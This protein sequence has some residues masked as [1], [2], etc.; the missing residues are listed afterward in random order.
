MKRI[1]IVTDNTCDLPAELLAKHEIAVVPLDVRLGDS[2]AAEMRGI[3]AEQ[4][5]Q[6]ARRSEALA[7]TSAP[8]PGAF[9][10][11]FAAAAD[12][13]CAGVVCITISSGLSATFQAARAGAE[14]FQGIFPVAVIDSFAASLALGLLVLE[15]VDF[16]AS[17]ADFP[18][19]VAAVQDEVP[20]T[21]VYGTLDTLEYLRRG[22]RIGNAQ[23]FFGSLLSIKPVIVMRDGV[24]E[25]ESRQRT[26]A[27]S[28]E[29][30]AAKAA[31]LSPLKRLA[32]GHADADDVDQFLDLLAP[33][34]PRSEIL[35]AY[36]GPI[37]GAHTGPGTM[38]LF[39]MVE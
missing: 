12:D 9:H 37:I 28:L 8:A 33:V 18:T 5:W 31:A 20:K 13:G 30:L 4:F 34:F 15:A 24:V 10:D 25:A 21:F 36:L 29:Y 7:E 11:A 6:I 14:S 17:G 32:V 26:R 3:S 16:V 35:V 22:G 2:D 38:A 39:P 19:T 1:R 23:A 27:R